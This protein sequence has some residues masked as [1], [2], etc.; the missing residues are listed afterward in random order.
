MGWGRRGTRVGR[1]V[2]ALVAG[3]LVVGAGAGSAAGAPAA[4]GTAGAGT[5]VAAGE[6]AVSGSFTGDG[7]FDSTAACP[8][9]H[10]WHDVSGDW[11]GLGAVTLNLDYCVELATGG[12]SPLSGT[13]TIT[14]PD[15]TLTGTV[16]GE[17]AG[18]PEPEGYPADYAL[19]VTGGTGAFAGATGTLALAAFWNHPSAPVLSIFGTVSGTIVVGLPT[20]S[21]VHDCLRGG[22]RAFADDTGRPFESQADCIR[23]V[24]HHGD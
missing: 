7:G 12:P 9:F 19:T 11:T 22:W 6:V 14:A 21:T 15:G 3:L 4:P 20:P 16:E 5:E 10:T 13:F 23:F 24:V 8:T 17:V 2:G 1:A 18:A